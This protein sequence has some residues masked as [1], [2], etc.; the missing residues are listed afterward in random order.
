MTTIK[1]I[2]PNYITEEEKQNYLKEYLEEGYKVKIVY[3]YDIDNDVYILE[4]IKEIKVLVP[5]YIPQEAKDKYLEEYLNDGY[6]IKLVYDY[7]V[8]NDV[9]VLNK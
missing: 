8:D 7:D 4:N 9:Y 3:D 6:I 5:N 1:I 2:V